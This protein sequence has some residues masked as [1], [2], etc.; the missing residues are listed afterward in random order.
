MIVYVHNLSGESFKCEILEEDTIK[1]FIDRIIYYR[2]FNKIWIPN[3][4]VIK[5][6]HFKL[7]YKGEYIKYQNEDK[8]NKYGFLNNDKIYIVD[9]ANIYSNNK[10]VD[11]NDFQKNHQ[12]IFPN[13]E[14][15]Q[16]LNTDEKISLILDELK[17][18]KDYVY[19][20]K[21]YIKKQ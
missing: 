9:S 1:S 15:T 20:I 17:I 14:I 18:L 3:D 11:N 4:F 2:N 6:N 21:E 13:I 8:I 5:S 7:I 12:I 19:E 10:N 16:N